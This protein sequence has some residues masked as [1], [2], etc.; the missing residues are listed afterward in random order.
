MGSAATNGDHHWGPQHTCKGNNFEYEFKVTFY[1]P[2]ENRSA[3]YKLERL[4]QTRSASE[5]TLE[6]R[7]LVA[8]LGWMSDEQLKRAFYSGLKDCV[9]D[10]LARSPDP[11][12]LNDMAF[13]AI[14][15]DNRI[16]QRELEKRSS[17]SITHKPSAPKTTTPA[18][19]STTAPAS[20]KGV[21][22]MDLS[23]SKGCIS[24]EEHLII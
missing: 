2:D 18:F 23:A 15:I 22:P 19:N 16:F 9:K 1:D 4:K 6:F 8:I 12:T 7:N 10:E 3:A 17:S 20:F 5:Y 24:P 13:L 14:S 11:A 21:V